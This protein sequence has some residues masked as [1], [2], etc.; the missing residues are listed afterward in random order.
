MEVLKLQ[1]R[2]DPNVKS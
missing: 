1:F 2:V